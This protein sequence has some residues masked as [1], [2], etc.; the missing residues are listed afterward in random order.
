M[1]VR[2]FWRSRPIGFQE[3][4]SPIDPLGTVVIE[5]RENYF[6][7]DVTLDPD[8][9]ADARLANPAVAARR[10]GVTPA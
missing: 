6:V 3:S 7:C 2:P 9:V 10:Y 8:R 1:R 5:A 4:T